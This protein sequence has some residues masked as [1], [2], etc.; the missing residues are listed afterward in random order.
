MCDIHE[1]TGSVNPGWIFYNIKELMLVFYDVIVVFND[2]YLL[3]LQIK[4][5]TNEMG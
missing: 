1:T 2:P 4:T 5:C 3:E